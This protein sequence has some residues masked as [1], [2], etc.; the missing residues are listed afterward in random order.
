MSEETSPEP[1]VYQVD[2]EGNVKEYGGVSPI[3]E[4]KHNIHKF[5]NEVSKSKDTTKTGFLTDI[6]LGTTPYAERTYKNLELQSKELCNDPLWADY[7]RQKA[8]IL[9][10]TSLS[11]NAKLLSL[12][13]LQRRE[14]ADMTEMKTQNKGWFSKK[15]KNI[16]AQP[17]Q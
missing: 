10:A 17:T 7:F 13:V 6:E 11:R 9:T 15:D 8:E 5:L 12:A 2:E 1:G 4:E 16:N 3:P 14:L